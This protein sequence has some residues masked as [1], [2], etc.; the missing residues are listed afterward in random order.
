LDKSTCQEH[1][2]VTDT[3]EIKMHSTDTCRHSHAKRHT[4]GRHLLTRFWHRLLCWQDLANQRRELA[5]LDARTLRDI[6]LSREDVLREASR[7]FWDSP[8]R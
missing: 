3:R 6:G 5:N 1:L 2:E 7:P 4:T 8:K